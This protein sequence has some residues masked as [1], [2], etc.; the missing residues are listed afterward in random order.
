MLSVN[1][2]GKALDGNFCWLNSELF[3]LV[4]KQDQTCDCSLC[5]FLE[6]LETCLMWVCDGDMGI[7]VA[8]EV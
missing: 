7:L 3:L 5:G 6:D 1:V 8:Y 4:L 2:L